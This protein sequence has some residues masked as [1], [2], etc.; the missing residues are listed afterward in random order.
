MRSQAMAEQRG[1]VEFTVDGHTVAALTAGP[2][3]AGG[4]PLIIALHGGT[5][6]GR[7]F[8]V[9]GSGQ[10]TFLDVA[11]AGGWPVVSFDR[12]GY[13]GSTALEPADNTFDRHASMLADAIGQAATQA[14]ADRVF[15]VG[16]SIGG[17][18]ALMI[19]AGELDVRLVG[20]SVTGV[21][22]VIRRGGAAD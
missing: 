1:S 8:D 13:G 12:P 7:Y 9:D 22:A 16:H 10:G 17:M 20:L 6:N 4:R 15:L 14:G 2:A 11:A 5:Y 3:A 21:G 19:A 18:I